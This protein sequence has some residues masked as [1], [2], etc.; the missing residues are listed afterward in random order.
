MNDVNEFQHA[1][2]TLIRTLTPY[3]N[4]V[5]ECFRQNDCDTA[6]ELFRQQAD[7]DSPQDQQALRDLGKAF[8]NFGL[9]CSESGDLGWAERAYS[10]A[11]IILCELLDPYQAEAAAAL[12]QMGSF[13]RDHKNDPREAFDYF[14]YALDIWKTVVKE[15][16]APEYI[17][18]LATTLHALGGIFA[19]DG[20]FER[21]HQNLEQA[22]E[23][24]QSILPEGHPDIAQSL[25]DLGTLYMLEENLPTA[26]DYLGQALSIYQAAM[27]PDDPMTQT[28][29]S[30]LQ[31][32]AP[33]DVK[34]TICTHVDEQ[35]QHKEIEAVVHT[36]D[37]EILK[38][39]TSEIKE[40][41]SEEQLSALVNR[42]GEKYSTDDVRVISQP[43]PYPDPCPCCGER[44]HTIVT[45]EDE[46]L[47]QWRTALH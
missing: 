28:V 4:Q 38:W 39:H 32:I 7:L 27:G 45:D 18:Q 31:S 20:E 19:E 36:G 34:I 41:L 17:V 37:G 29:A 23:L 26:R 44:Q 15:E 13:F 5:I 47:G 16:N 43:L 12:Y 25:A 30:T 6:L 40:M 22:L 46:P 33:Q 10:F 1:K 11:V 9:A 3:G 8:A 2:E 14:A 24:R 35:T 21:A 42:L